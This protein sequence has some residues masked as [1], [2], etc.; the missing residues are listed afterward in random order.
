[1][2]PPGYLNLDQVG[3][4]NSRCSCDGPVVLALTFQEC[5]LLTSTLKPRCFPGLFGKG[6]PRA[7]VH[8]TLFMSSLLWQADEAN[9]CFFLDGCRVPKTQKLPAN[10]PANLPTNLVPV[11]PANFSR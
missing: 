11:V 8:Q 3:F 9:H 1:M 7:G 4:T 2:Q 10:L 6:W 5:L